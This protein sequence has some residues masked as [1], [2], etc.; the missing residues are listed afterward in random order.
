MPSPAAL[1]GLLPLEL[2]GELT[3]LLAEV[4]AD[5]LDLLL[6]LGRRTTLGDV[7]A[8]GDHAVARVDVRDA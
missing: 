6:G 2:I 5:H 7:E 8:D 1:A 4:A 3:G